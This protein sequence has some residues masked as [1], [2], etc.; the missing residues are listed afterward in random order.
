MDNNMGRGKEVEDQWMDLLPM[1]MVGGNIDRIEQHVTDLER[2]SEDSSREE[3]SSQESV[4]RSTASTAGGSDD[5]PEVRRSKEEVIERNRILSSESW[6][7]YRKGFSIPNFK[8]LKAKSLVINEGGLLKKK[9]SPVLVIGKGKEILEEDGGFIMKSFNSPV[10][11]NEVIGKFNLEASSSNG[12]RIASIKSFNYASLPSSPSRKDLAASPQLKIKSKNDDK[13]DE[14]LQQR[15]DAES[16]F[17]A[18]IVANEIYVPKLSP[19]NSKKTVEPEG[20]C[21]RDEHSVPESIAVLERTSEENFGTVH[22]AD[23]PEE[24]HVVETRVYSSIKI[25]N[26]FDVLAIMEESNLNEAVEVQEC[27][28]AEEGEI[29]EK[30]PHNMSNFEALC[31]EKTKLI[32][33]KDKE[34][35]NS[36]K[37]VIGSLSYGKKVKLINEFKSL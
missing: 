11:I 37:V 29:V 14:E 6:A 12:P 31:D 21:S 1:M 35:S 18:P 17:R 25:I 22:Q 34:V 32:H 3:G 13:V 24:Q 28:C 10:S 15:I 19:G 33:R 8:N 20:V 27:A 23:I 9:I 7:N 36:E 4:E 16:S 30:S 5:L 26:K 2:E